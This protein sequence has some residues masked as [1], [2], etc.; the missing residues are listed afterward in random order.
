M[1]FNKDFINLIYI[2][3]SLFIILYFL[4]E[5]IG[6]NI[7]EKWF[8]KNKK[9]DHRKISKDL[10]ISPFV[11][12]LLVN[13]D[14]TDYDL[15]NRFI[16]P[17]LSKLYDPILMKDL[18]KAVNIIK[19]KIYEKKRIRIVGDFDVDGVMSVF[20]LYTSIKKCGGVVDYVIPDRV[21]DGYG[22]NNEIIEKAKLDGID[23]II[24]CDNGIAAIEQVK[25][26]KEIGLTIIVTDHH[27]IP[28]II[29]EE[30]HKKY[31][32]LEA[33]AVV[34]PK[35][36]ECKYPFKSLCG[37]GVAFK[38]IQQLYKAMNL[39]FEESYQLLEY[40]AI[41]TVCDVVDL[42]D[43]N[44]VI[45]KK[46]LELINNTNN[47]GLNA[48]IK[49]TGIEGKNLGVY[50]LGFIIGPCINA[51]GRLDSA[52]LSL[53]LL[54]SNN[55]DEATDLARDLKELN[56]ERK[57]MTI[58]GVEKVVD[59]IENSNL[60]DDKV[61]VIYEPEIHESIAGIIA[62]RIKDKYY[63]PTIILT[64]GEQGVKGSGRSIEEYNMFEELSKCKDL[65]NRFGGHPMA[66]GLSLDP[67]N[68]DILR[69]RL[70][71]ETSLTD[72]DL[73]PKVYIDMQ[74]PLDFINFNLIEELK[75]LEPFGKGNNKPIFGE[76][77]LK[78]KRGFVF[79]NNRNVLKLILESNS[80]K[81]I[82]GL[83]FGNIE[84]FEESINSKYGKEEIAKLYDGLNNRLNMDIL[85]T[86]S[87]NE[88]MGNT[89][90]QVIIQNYR[91]S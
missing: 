6:V 43:E 8:I 68:I 80:G 87:V 57:C 36:L 54:L 31:I 44:R 65:L 63:V 53:K 79:G 61:F 25:L 67:C 73:I 41:A 28:F 38:L 74:L 50:H 20:I 78:V 40:V 82:D 26:A 32:S 49:E 7:L 64:E 51:S 13:R 75:L 59:I 85:F 29:N 58:K 2:Y 3:R 15:I 12:K 21:K 84:D 89:T 81:T 33:D 34:N 23:T 4:L 76:K 55:M 46:G 1:N 70:N 66:A 35:Q 69:N 83:Y 22:I 16:S 5:F 10:G 45:V 88:Y 52:L 18:E 56:E 77:G 90:L 19:D 72:D 14:I 11:S 42:I 62:G 17:Q 37:A 48:L 47:M 27:D 60:K 91:W 39:P 30:N 71:K 86:P 24:T 9:V